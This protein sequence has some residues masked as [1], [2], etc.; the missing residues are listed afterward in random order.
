[1]RSHLT[2]FAFLILLSSCSVKK[3][4]ASQFPIEIYSVDDFYKKVVIID[5]ACMNETKRAEKDIA[6]GRLVIS[7]Y[8]SF[9]AP[10]FRTKYLDLD[11]ERYIRP[12]FKQYNITL[13]TNVVMISDVVFP[14]DHFFSKNCYESRM[15]AEIRKRYGGNLIDSI[16]RKAEQQYVAD[17]PDRIFYLREKDRFIEQSKKLYEDC[18]AMAKIK[19]KNSFIYP[20][21]YQKKNGKKASYT[22]ADFVLMKDGTIKDLEVVSTFQNPEN[23]KFR[24][25]F[26]TEVTKFVKSVKWV[27]PTF[28]GVIRNSQMNFIFFHQ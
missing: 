4:E 6:D 24:A 11:E 16:I 12:Q 22:D 26:E 23:E 15:R 8:S 17:N 7:P 18:M 19:L 21:G 10:E 20:E 13:D 1:M 27:H 5:T 28:S 3:K 14:H 25:Y 9:M 2:L